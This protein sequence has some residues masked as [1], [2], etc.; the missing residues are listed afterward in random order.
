MNATDIFYAEVVK[1]AGVSQILSGAGK[2]LK[3]FAKR[4]AHGATGAYA[5][6]AAEIGLNPSEVA[7]GITSF[8]GLARGLVS[9]PKKTL[10][11]AAKST[12]SGKAGLAAGVGIPTAIATPSLLRGDESHEGG[13]TVR[14]KLVGY[15]SNM[16]GGVLTGG[17]PIIPGLV[18]SGIIDSASLKMLGG[19]KKG[20][21]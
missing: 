16:A 14:Q 15:G 18:G 7:A 6:Q 9:N 2:S 1:R 21:P 10:G 12:F 13:Q 8:P 17:M 4:Q 20:A 11:A 19:K 5:H 3:N